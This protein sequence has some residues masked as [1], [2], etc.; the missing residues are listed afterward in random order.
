[1][2]TLEAPKASSSS[3]VLKGEATLETFLSK[4]GQWLTAGAAALTHPCTHSSLFPR[5]A[6]AVGSFSIWHIAS[7]PRSAKSVRGASSIAVTRV[8][9]TNVLD[10]GLRIGEIGRRMNSKVKLVEIGVYRK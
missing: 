3:P 10:E 4:Q 8:N 1:V 9:S 7:E 6:A 5:A 2:A